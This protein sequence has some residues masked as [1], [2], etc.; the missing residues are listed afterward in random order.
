LV[1][2]STGIEWII[3]KRAERMIA[4]DG[5]SRRGSTMAAKR[6]APR[7]TVKNP[8]KK[9]TMRVTKKRAPAKKAS[10]ARKVTKKWAPAKKAAK[11]TT[12]KE[13]KRAPARKAV[14]RRTTKKAAAPATK[15]ATRRRTTPTGFSKLTPTQQ[16]QIRLD[17]ETPI[18]RISDAAVAE[19]KKR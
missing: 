14:K 8:V 3:L 13:A 7:K 18:G 16:R 11:R 4:N 9:V 15:A 12:K 10:P 17:R 1:T 6:A 5:T 19:W 2:T